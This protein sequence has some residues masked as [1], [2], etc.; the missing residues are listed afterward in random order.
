MSA[1]LRERLIAPLTDDEIAELR[2]L[3]I[4]VL[5]DRLYVLGSDA[6]ANPE[7][8]DR[9]NATVTPTLILQLTRARAAELAP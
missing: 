7:L 4:A 5:A 9:W 2:K 1:S 6:W 8:V 3:A